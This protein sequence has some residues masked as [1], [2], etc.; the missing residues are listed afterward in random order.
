MSAFLRTKARTNLRSLA[1][2][3]Q[4]LCNSKIAASPE[5]AGIATNSVPLSGTNNPVLAPGAVVTRLGALAGVEADT[6]ST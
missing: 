5:R 4:W 3:D 2:A 6:T 1:P